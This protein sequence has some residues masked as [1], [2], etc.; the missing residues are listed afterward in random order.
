MYNS[1]ILELGTSDD[2]EW[3]YYAWPVPWWALVKWIAK[4]YGCFA[5]YCFTAQ[6]TKVQLSALMVRWNVG[7]IS[8]LNKILNADVK[9]L[10]K[11]LS[12]EYHD[13]CPI[14]VSCTHFDI[15][16]TGDSIIQLCYSWTTIPVDQISP[17][18]TFLIRSNLWKLKFRS[19]AFRLIFILCNLG[20]MHK[21]PDRKFLLGVMC[22]LRVGICSRHCLGSTWA[23]LLRHLTHTFIGEALLSFRSAVITSDNVLLQWRPE[24]PD[25]CKWKGVTCDSV[26]K[27]VIY[28]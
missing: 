15:V 13:F 11:V 12:L 28:L 14:P 5:F 24:D 26:S 21:K 1:I 2:L 10:L 7:L 25:P 6:S 17:S 4:E 22:S 18:C 16:F 3:L 27:N 9:S 20:Y 23:F 19:L 8:S